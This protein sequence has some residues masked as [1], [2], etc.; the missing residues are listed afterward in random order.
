MSLYEFTD[1]TVGTS[2]LSLP[3]ESITFNGHKLDS[4]LVGYQ[5]LNVEGRSNFTRSV[6]TATGLF[7]G[8]LFLSSR[9][10]SNKINVK[11]MVAAKTNSDFNVLNDSL[12]NYLQGNEVAFKFADEP[13]Y[14]R[15]GTVTSNV[16]D[17]PGRLST[18]GVFEITMSDPYKYGATKNLSGTNAITISDKTLSYAQG[19]DTIV[20]TN[21]ADVSK[22]VLTVGSYTLTLTGS[23]E[24]GNTYTIDYKAK[25][26]TELKPSTNVKKSVNATIDIN[27]SDIFEAKIKNGT[28][29]ASAQA[30]S[31]SLSYKVKIL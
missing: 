26:I 3:S 4:E 10:E 22:I 29:I 1:L 11:Y 24:A 2:A 23:F 19:F 6:S 20:L 30:S 31:I 28:K 8:D 17:N 18:T 21:S 9:I 27:N 5:T 16:L 7:D 13:D 15:Y 14:T 25:T 12:N